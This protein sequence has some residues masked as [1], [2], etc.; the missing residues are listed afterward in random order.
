MQRRL[1]RAGAGALLGLALSQGGALGFQDP[2][3]GRVSGATLLVDVREDGVAAVHLEVVLEAPPSIESVP[4]RAVT[5]G[6]RTPTAT[7]VTAGGRPLVVRWD[8]TPAPLLAGRADLPPA[9][10]RR[11]VLTIAYELPS[12][13][14]DPDRLDV[15]VPLV[16]VD[17][18]PE[19]APEGMFSARV[20]LPAGFAV[21][22]RF[23]TV[24]L[25][26][27]T[28]ADGRAVYALSLPAVPSMVRL[29]ARRG[30]VPLTFGARVDIAL[31]GALLLLA[32]VAWRYLRLREPSR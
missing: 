13:A 26:R 31:I 23:P 20:T 12:R 29:R 22:E 27:S 8:E 18:P 25:D 1:R 17:W 19:G 11:V 24:P 6:G 7:E 10:G 5:F 4:L 9:R 2:L 32:C 3:Q 21:E 28:A 14:E 30:A 16:G 15:W